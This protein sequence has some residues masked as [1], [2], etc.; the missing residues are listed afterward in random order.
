MSMGAIAESSIND[1]FESF[2]STKTSVNMTKTSNLGMIQHMSVKRTPMP[3]PIQ[4]E[5]TRTERY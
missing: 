2:E 3:S 4:D 5:I 1:V